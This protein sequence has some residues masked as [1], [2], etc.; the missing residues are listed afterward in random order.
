MMH[1]H[2]LMTLS[3]CDSHA[4]MVSMATLLAVM[5]ALMKHTDRLNSIY[6]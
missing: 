4:A 5:H 3:I 1:G 2:G 6:N